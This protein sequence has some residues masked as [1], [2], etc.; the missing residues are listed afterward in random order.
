M[1]DKY[2]YIANKITIFSSAYS[3]DDIR[4]KYH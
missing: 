4:H 1:Y 2:I 3:I